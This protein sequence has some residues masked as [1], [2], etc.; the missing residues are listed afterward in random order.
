[1]VIGLGKKRNVLSN[2]HKKLHYI[3]VFT[4]GCDNFF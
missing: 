3:G 4:A 1:M 2:L